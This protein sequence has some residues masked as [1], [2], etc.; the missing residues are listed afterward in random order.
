MLFL[1][2]LLL[3]I[4]PKLPLSFHTIRTEKALDLLTFRPFDLSTFRPFDLSTFRPNMTSDLFINL[5]APNGR[6]YK[7]PIGLFINNEFVK[8]KSGDK[9]TSINPT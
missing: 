8:S 7:Q 5:K 9:I 1:L 3:P 2:F 4:H 6:E